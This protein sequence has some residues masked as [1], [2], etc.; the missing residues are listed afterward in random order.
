MAEPTIPDVKAYAAAMA[1][2][3][4]LPLTPDYSPEVEANLTV[5]FRLS[6]L[7]LDFPLPDESEPAPV[8]RAREGAP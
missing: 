2:A 6:R 7:F 8:F 1:E 4:G 5:A 3:L